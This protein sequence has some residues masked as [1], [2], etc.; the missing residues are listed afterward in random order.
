MGSRYPL[1]TYLASCT[2]Y[3][4]TYLKLSTNGWLGGWFAVNPPTCLPLRFLADTFRPS[5]LPALFALPMGEHWL[6]V[7]WKEGGIPLK[8]TPLALRFL[9]D[10]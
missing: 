7:G 6:K 1:P 4:Y 5:C 8:G 10:S 2:T 3:M 9:G